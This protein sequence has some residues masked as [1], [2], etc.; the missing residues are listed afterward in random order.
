MINICGISKSF[1]KCQ[2]LDNVSFDVG[3][4]EIV[5]LLGENGAGKSTLLRIISTMLSP[6][7]GNASI[8]GF[9][10]ISQPREV[11]KNIGILFGSEVGLYDRL[12]ARENL[13]YFAELNGM[14]ASQTKQRV[15]E[16]AS[17]FEFEQYADKQV[18]TFSKGMKQKV[19]IARAIVHDPSVVL[20]DEPD[21]GL[22]FSA[23]RIVFNFMR[24]CKEKGKSIIFSSHSMENIKI[25]SDRMAV[26]HKGRLIKIFDMQEYRKMY[27]PEEINDMLFSLVCGGEENA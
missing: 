12:T 18:G 2:A 13:E 21:S 8:N 3:D 22:D 27:T 20:F 19:A 25:Y 16:L 14:S 24:F 6:T 4:G 7:S 11:R 5:G 17:Q 1:K 26:L 10:L 23:A 15:S 9:D